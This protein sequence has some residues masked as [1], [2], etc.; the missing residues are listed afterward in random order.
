[1]SRGS[2]LRLD[3]LT[4]TWVVF[5]AGRANR[6][7][8][9]KSNDAKVKLADLP[10]VVENCPFC[11]GNE[12]MLEHICLTYNDNDGDCV[13][14]V[15]NKYP[16]VDPMISNTETK[17][18]VVRKSM[19]N[20]EKAADF[21]IETPAVGFHEVIIESTNHN[22]HIAASSLE[23]TKHLL[24]AFRERGRAH[25][26]VEGVEHTCYFKNHG[27]TAGASLVH[28]HAQVVS[29]PVVPAE[30]ARL[31][32]LALDYFEKNRT[33]LYERIIDEELL[34]YYDDEDW[35][36]S[37]AY[38]NLEQDVPNASQS[39]VI[40]VTTNFVSMT[41]YASP[42]PYVI[43]IFPLFGPEKLDDGS[44]VDCSDFTTTNDELLEEC[45][46]I[47]KKSIMRLQLLLD[48]PCFNLVIQSSPLKTKGTRQA[49]FNSSVFFRWHIRI[50]PRLGAGAMGGFELGSGFFN[51]SHMPEH[52]AAELRAVQLPSIP[53]DPTATD[54]RSYLKSL[55]E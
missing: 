13:R 40:D 47:L 24:F 19:F 31:Q 26:K 32:S 12:H 11:K 53:G 46:V 51:N 36:H 22:K 50:T 8:Q 48:E 39:R 30:A 20:P 38:L 15:P 25:A 54:R 1:M 4:G 10:S 42:G 29:T 37:K 33:S 17:R 49:A 18:A 27:A 52:D 28:P 35:T 2:V 44:G 43:T 7:K 3:E 9:T 6:P 5:A 41:P 45:A 21:K 23:N 14:V 55:K 16:A 34:L